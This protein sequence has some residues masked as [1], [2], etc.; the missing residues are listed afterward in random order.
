MNACNRFRKQVSQGHFGES[1]RD[2]SL[3]NRNHIESCPECREWIIQFGKLE[4]QLDPPQEIPSIDPD[5]LRRMKRNVLSAIDAAPI[6]TGF[7]QSLLLSPK[8]I[9]FS[10]AAALLSVI[11]AFRIAPIRHGSDQD[12][13]LA[14][15]AATLM[16]E[17][18]DTLDTA[19]PEVLSQA[20]WIQIDTELMPF[21]EDEIETSDSTGLSDSMLETAR[22]FQEDDWN[23]LRRYLS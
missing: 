10:S 20:L 8:L 11:I 22:S 7:L 4:E 15:A 5:V 6:R 2:V 9:A 16:I 1:L 12:N 19:D 17:E 13:E 18:P 23:A 21:I 3:S 14:I